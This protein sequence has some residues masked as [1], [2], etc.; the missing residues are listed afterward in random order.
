MVD[1]EL[2]PLRVLV[3]FPLPL[4]VVADE[5]GELPDLEE[6]LLLDWDWDWDEDWLLDCGGGFVG[7]GEGDEVGVLGLEVGSWAATKVTNSK[8]I[9]TRTRRKTAWSLIVSGGG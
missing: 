3:P 7:L 6:D 8:S 9:R 1:W 2:L 5:A 4:L